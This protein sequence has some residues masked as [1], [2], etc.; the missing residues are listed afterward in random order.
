MSRIAKYP[1]T[2]PKGVE[3]TLAPQT[4]SI[5]GPLG[6]LTQQ[7]R[8]DVKVTEYWSLYASH[9]RDLAK[10]GCSLANSAGIRYLDECFDILLYA[11]RYFYNIGDQTQDLTIGLRIRLANL[12]L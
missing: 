5:K 6:T 12:G 7:L 2:L 9:T 8:G 4:L 3:A 11:D 10:G 1:V